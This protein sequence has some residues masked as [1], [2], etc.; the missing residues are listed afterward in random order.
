M[1]LGAFPIP[2][3]DSR[4]PMRPRGGFSIPNGVHTLR[5]FPLNTSRIPS[6]QF[7]AFT[8][9]RYLLAVTAAGFPS[10]LTP[11]EEGLSK[12]FHH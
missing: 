5:S 11:S 4:R 7:P 2:K 10:S 12:E 6:P 3:D 8:K 1:N 9:D